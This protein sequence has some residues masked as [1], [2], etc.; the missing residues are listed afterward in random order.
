MKLNFK[1]M[2]LAVSLTV[3]AGVAAADPFDAT[4]LIDLTNAADFST[5]QTALSDLLV[6]TFADNSVAAF[7]ENV[8][9]I[10]QTGDGTTVLAIIDQSGGVGNLAVIQQ[11]ASSNSAVAVVTQ[12]GSNNRALVNQH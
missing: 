5:R 4:T 7:D 6:D 1:A 9:L 8:A 12:L 2:A 10:N 3:L 11:D